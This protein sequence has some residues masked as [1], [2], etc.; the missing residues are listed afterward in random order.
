MDFPF[1]SEQLKEKGGLLDTGGFYRAVFEKPF[2][3]DLESARKINNTISSIFG[4]DNIYR[5][6]HYLGK[7]MIQNINMVRFSNQIF[8]AV[9]N[10]D[11]IDNVQISVKESVGGVQERG[12]YYDTSGGH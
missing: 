5:I 11:S 4:E 6:D 7:E 10:K 1:I 12:G 3:Y 2:G 9:W 8:S